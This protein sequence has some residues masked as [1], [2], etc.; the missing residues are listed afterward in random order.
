MVSVRRGGYLARART[1]AGRLGRVRNGHQDGKAR[2]IVSILS[3]A[4]P[5]SRPEPSASL[6]VEERLP[7]YVTDSVR[8]PEVVSALK[9]SAKIGLDLETTGLR[10]WRDKIRLLSLTT[11]SGVT[12][13]I[14][15]FKVDISL[16]FPALQSTLIVAHNAIFDL[17]FLKR[18]GFEPGRYTCTKILSQ[19][20]WAGKLK[21]NSDNNVEHNLEAVA[22]RTLGKTL[23]KSSQKADWAGELTSEMLRYA[24]SDSEVLLPIYEELTRRLHA[25][26]LDEVV[27]LEERFL[28]VVAHITENGLPVD[29]AKWESYIGSTEEEKTDLRERM[30]AFVTEPLTEKFAKANGANKKGVPE[31]RRDKVNWQSGEQIGWVF[32]LH[33][34]KLAKTDKGRCSTDKDTLAGVDHALAPLVS[35]F[36]QIKNLPSTFGDAIQNRYADGRIY[37]DWNQCEA[38]TGRMSCSKPPMQGA[39]KAGELR[40]AV[41]ASPGFKL[42]VSDLSQI[43]VR[44]LASLS[45]DDVARGAYV[46]GRDIYREV[47]RKV[48]GRDDVSDE[49]RQICK[50]IVLGNMYGQG[51]EGMRRRIELRLNRPFPVE[52]ARAYWSGFFDEFPGIKAWRERL[53]AEFVRGS[54]ETRTRLGRRRL[55]VNNKRQRWNAPIQGLACDVL[56]SIA[57]EVYERRHEVPGLK[58]VGLIHDEVLCLV[59]EKYAAK[60]EHW[61]TEIME[62]IGDNVVNGRLAQE[63]RVPI[64]ATT[65]VCNNWGE[66]E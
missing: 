43:E 56:K 49:E 39:P 40:K 33:G 58:V 18:L 59:P 57:V 53:E 34:I 25:A 4:K 11:E 35:R 61:L 37:A 44:V 1:L 22:H 55:D 20:L 13:V 28:E 19:I 7:F 15:A 21:K 50:A 66:K 3:P 30:D 63:K 17:L 29:K 10:W 36:N 5:S 47:A 2:V 41:V 6:G 27:A 54:R 23:D 9:A 42:V 26:G 65:K 16:F 46:A 8:L 62:T 12:W 48:M 24:A 38:D 60:A 45:E 51:I 31:E 64:K 32:S 14:D 52:E